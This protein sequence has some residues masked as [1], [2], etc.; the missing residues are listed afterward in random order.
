MPKRPKHLPPVPIVSRYGDAL[1]AMARH[2]APKH[3]MMLLHHFASPA[4][5]TTASQLARAVDYKDWNSVNLQYGTFAKH[6]ADQMGWIVPAGSPAL[7]AICWFE[8][9]PGARQHWRL[10]MHHELADAIKALGWGT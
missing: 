5:R 6:L 4:H 2:M 1:R 9:P 10:V 8:M 7:Y 3:R